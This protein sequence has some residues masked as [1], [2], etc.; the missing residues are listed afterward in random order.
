M[1]AKSAKKK[2]DHVDYVVARADSGVYCGERVSET[3][4]G[5]GRMTL[6]LRNFR[7]IWKWE[8]FIGVQA[9]HTV[10]D[11]SVYGV[12]PTSKVSAVAAAITIADARCAVVCS[13]R[14]RAILEAAKWAQ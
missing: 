3:P 11:I 8:G 10:E 1:A 14:A 9:V 12:G 13:G 2:L 6:R 5:E 7:R 4:N